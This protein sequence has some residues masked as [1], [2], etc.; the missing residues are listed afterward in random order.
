MTYR[1]G[2]INIGRGCWEVLQLLPKTF[3]RQTRRLVC[4]HPLYLLSFI[5]IITFQVVTL[6]NERVSRDADSKEIY[7]LQHTLDSIQGKQVKYYSFNANKHN[8]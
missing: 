8:S 7:R 2:F 4:N 5:G 6:A 1:H 3:T